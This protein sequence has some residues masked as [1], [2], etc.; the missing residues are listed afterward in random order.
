MPLSV[1]TLTTCGCNTPA[2]SNH[3]D[4]IPH[5][6]PP[7]HPISR[8]TSDSANEYTSTAS[9]TANSSISNQSLYSKQCYCCSVFPRSSSFNENF[10]LAAGGS[11]LVLADNIINNTGS[12]KQGHKSNKFILWRTILT[13]T[14]DYFRVW[15]T[16][17]SVIIIAKKLTRLNVFGCHNP[18]RLLA[19]DIPFF[20]CTICLSIL[21]TM[22][23]ESSII[24]LVFRIDRY[25]P[26][27]HD[28][29]TLSHFLTILA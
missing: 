11:S 29:I 20:C 10:L 8:W 12:N 23:Y 27:A 22:V 9:A 19:I 6:L 18:K 26:H 1:F 13:A 15:I 21:T 25:S 3:R 28:V 14:I 7:S 16:L 17:A 24:S 2:E 5:H 4:H